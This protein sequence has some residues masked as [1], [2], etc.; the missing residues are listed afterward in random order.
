[1]TWTGLLPA[2]SVCSPFPLL[3]SGVGWGLEA[4]MPPQQVNSRDRPSGSQSQAR[5]GRSGCFPVSS[6]WLLPSSPALKGHPGHRVLP[7]AWRWG[8]SS[9]SLPILL[10]PPRLSRAQHMRWTML[11]QGPRCTSYV[12]LTWSSQN[13]EFRL[14]AKF[15]KVTV[16]THQ[17]HLLGSYS[18]SALGPPCLWR[19]L[20][21]SACV[22]RWDAPAA[23]AGA[24]SSR[25]SAG[26]L[27]NVA[28]D[29]G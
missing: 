23:G 18:S 1:M 5:E 3:S 10:F 29:S 13:M 12:A 14:G 17:A 28:P 15:S 24:N 19:S 26:L 2:G 8:P 7:L 9:Q 16:G 22:N 25:N 4:T 27:E 11:L 20:W 21:T 6:L